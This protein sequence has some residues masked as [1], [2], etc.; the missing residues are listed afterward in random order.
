MN[1]FTARA[2]LGGMVIRPILKQT[3]AI[4]MVCKRDPS[5]SSPAS[6]AATAFK[7]SSVSEC[8]TPLEIGVLLVGEVNADVLPDSPVPSASIRGTGRSSL[9]DRDSN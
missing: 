1:P 8:L 2:K 5:G 6:W 9:A 7:D 3:C 4:W